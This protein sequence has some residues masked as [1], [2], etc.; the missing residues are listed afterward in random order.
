MVLPFFAAGMAFFAVY[1]LLFAHE[2]R[3]KLAP[4]VAPPQ[5]LA[6]AS[7]AGVGI[8][9]PCSESISIGTAQTGIVLEVFHGP[10]DVGVRVPKGQPLFRVDDRALRAQLA[11]Q[12]AKLKAAEANLHRLQQL[13]RKEDIPPLEARVKVAKARALDLK[14][15]YL[16]AKRIE[17]PAI[18]DEEVS[19]RRFAWEA[20]QYSLL[21]AQTELALLRAGAWQ[22]DVAIAQAAID[23]ARA[24]LAYIESEIERCL[25]RAPIDAEILQVQVRVGEHVSQQNRRDLMILGD[26]SQRYVRID[27]DQEDIPRYRP[28]A[29]ASAVVRG[30]SARSYSMNYV[31]SEWYVIPKRTLTGDNT[32]RVDTRVLQ[33]IYRLEGMAGEL[34]VGQQVDVFFESDTTSPLPSIPERQA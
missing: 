9:E 18:S 16:R 4:I 26:V 25:V 10:E 31:R 30:D 6:P 24:H 22:P 8:V 19:Q 15:R 32:E 3:P 21:Q 2:P 11:V 1:H 5:A 17:G 28:A 29:P 12:Q 27:I 23:Q 7:V 13:P 34:R 20:A 14:D 33:V